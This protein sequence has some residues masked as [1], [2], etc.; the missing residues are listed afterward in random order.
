MIKYI[1]TDDT[2]AYRDFGDF[3]KQAMKYAKTHKQTVVLAL[4]TELQ[5]VSVLYVP[6]NA[7]YVAPCYEFIVN[8]LIS[9]S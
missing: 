3:E 1:T 7:I 2:L 8:H 9:V 6:G 5:V 4:E